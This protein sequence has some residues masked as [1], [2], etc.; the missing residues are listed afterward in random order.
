M[1]AIRSYYEFK[2][3]GEWKMSDTIKE[4]SNQTTRLYKLQN[5]MFLDYINKIKTYSST[6][7]TSYNVCYTKLL[8]A[9]SEGAGCTL[10]NYAIFAGGRDN[11]GS[12]STVNAYN[13]SLVRTVL[14]NL[15]IDRYG[16]AGANTD[17]YALFAGGYSYSTSNY[18]A[19]VDTYDSNLVKGTITSLRIT[20]Y[21]VC[22]T[23]LLRNQENQV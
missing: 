7:I 23:K 1:Y 18:S 13:A 20:S 4:R 21:N 12:V 5:E 2:K 22:Y 16:L 6:R 8:R 9:I 11:S 19:I 17:D 15:S 10:G 14:T 3:V